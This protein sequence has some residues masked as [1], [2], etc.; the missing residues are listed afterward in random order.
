MLDKV[1][2]T[3]PWFE[4]HINADGTYHTCGAQPNTIT[5]SELQNV[6]NVANMSIPEWIN[7]QHQRQARIKKVNGQQ[8]PLCSICYHEDALHNSSKRT[9]ENLKVK[10]TPI[11]F[12][13]SYKYNPYASKFNESADTGYTSILNPTS[14]HL[15]L[16]N[17]CNL[18]CKMCNPASSSKIAAQEIRLG[19]YNGPVR[20]N[21]TDNDTAWE[22][23]ISHMCSTETLEYVHIVGGEPLITPKFEELVDRLIAANRTNIYL[24]FTTNGTIYN[25]KLLDKLNL[26]KHV[27]IGISIECAGY[28]NNLI[29]SGSD[30]QLVLDNI[31]LYL[32]RRDPNHVYITV[33]TAPNALS[34]HTLDELLKWCIERRI[35]VMSNIL[36]GPEYLQIRH[37]PPDIKEKLLIQYN[38]W[39]FSEPAPTWTNPRDPNW[40]KQHIDN[41]IKAII[42]S[43]KL[44]NET[45]LTAQ[46]YSNLGTWNWLKNPEIAKYFNTS[47]K[48]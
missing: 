17:E 26:F 5:G 31:D 25:E 10:I 39:E 42:K 38:R 2:C 13:K 14:Y 44:P 11:N 47:F 7:S 27:D 6:Y 40:F 16:G 20:L 22:H 28:L 45:T 33:R 48:A 35:D 29:R 18:A 4:V 1:F 41:D 46:L 9:R 15:S 30:T 43:L 8:E 3:V 37:L 19:N 34:V 21:W 36:V 32:K 24:G 23:V 12:H